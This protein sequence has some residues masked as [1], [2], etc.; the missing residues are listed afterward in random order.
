MHRRQGPH[1]VPGSTTPAAGR[2]TT[3]SARSNVPA[4]SGTA[5]TSTSSF[6]NGWTSAVAFCGNACRNSQAATP[7]DS[8]NRIVS[9]VLA[10]MA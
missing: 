1:D 4:D 8:R 7:S 2:H 5:A 10:R 6:G 3:S 9:S